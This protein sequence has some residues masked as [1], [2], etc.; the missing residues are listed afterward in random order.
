MNRALPY[1]SSIS[2]AKSKREQDGRARRGIGN[3]VFII[4][5]VTHSGLVKIQHGEGGDYCHSGSFFKN[6]HG[7]LNGTPLEA[8]KNVCTN[9]I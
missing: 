9:R 7:M 5:M 6:W 8:D 2:G 1:R 3:N 4:F